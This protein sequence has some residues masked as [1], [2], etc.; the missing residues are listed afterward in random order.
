MLTILLVKKTNPSNNQYFP[1]LVKKKDTLLVKQL[2][3]NSL[4]F[5]ETPRYL[6]ADNVTINSLMRTLLVKKLSYSFTKGKLTG[7]GLLDTGKTRHVVLRTLTN[8]SET[9]YADIVLRSTSSE[10]APSPIAQ[11]T[12]RLGQFINQYVNPSLNR[13]PSFKQYEGEITDEQIISQKLFEAVTYESLNQNQITV[14]YRIN[15]VSRQIK[16]DLEDPRA[17][18]FLN[19]VSRH[20][21]RSLLELTE[22]KEHEPELFQEEYKVIRE[23]L[24]ATFDINLV[25]NIIHELK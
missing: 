2:L 19:A 11:G 6:L 15:G 16:I 22:I 24:A 5:Q 23:T 3:S 13:N 7:W 21:E 4:V 8:S 9:P 17:Q 18:T 10:E 12:N 20:T 25:T 1:F 14:W